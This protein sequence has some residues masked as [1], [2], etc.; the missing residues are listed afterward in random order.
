MR[1]AGFSEGSQ[2][3]IWEI[4][5]RQVD[6]LVPEALAS[7][8]GRRAARLPGH[9][10]STARKVHG[11][12]GAVVDNEIRTIRALDPLDLRSVRIR[13]AGPG[14]LRHSSSPSAPRSRIRTVSRTRTPSTPT[15]C[16]S[17]R[18]EW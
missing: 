12:E 9:G 3:G 4:S 1:A 10:R 5:G 11:I 7:P 2:P 14:A 8:A 17:C 16:C 13:V 18:P 6:L 15:G